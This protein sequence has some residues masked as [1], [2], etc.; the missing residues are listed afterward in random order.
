MNHPSIP[1]GWTPEPE[2]APKH[3]TFDE[4]AYTV[5]ITLTNAAVTATFLPNATCGMTREQWERTLTR[6]QERWE[7]LPYVAQ[8]DVVNLHPVWERDFEELMLFALN[9]QLDPRNRPEPR[10]GRPF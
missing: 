7:M 1:E 8:R 10:R 9:T 5:Y 3:Y 2:P 6:L 4:G